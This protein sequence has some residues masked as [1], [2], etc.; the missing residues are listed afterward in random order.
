MSANTDE[1][2]K[3]YFCHE[4]CREEDYCMGCKTYI[5]SDC[6]EIIPVFTEDHL[7][8]D[9]QLNIGDVMNEMGGGV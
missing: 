9:H 7:P 5:C 2:H 3:C 1:V 8:Q 4:T 6:D